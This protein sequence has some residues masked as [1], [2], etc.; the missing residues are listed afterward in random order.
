MICCCG[1]EVNGAFHRIG[2][3]HCLASS[4]ASSFHAHAAEHQH[5]D[6]HPQLRQP[7]AV[8][9]AKANHVCSSSAAITQAHSRALVMMKQMN[10]GHAACW[11]F[12]CIMECTSHCF[13]CATTV[14]LCKAGGTPLADTQ[15]RNAR[16][17]VISASGCCSTVTECHML[18]PCRVSGSVAAAGVNWQLSRRAVTGRLG[19]GRREGVR[20]HSPQRPS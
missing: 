12:L 5:L 4:C 10:T 18:C 14:R 8:P 17:R 6:N 19:G 20:Q 16:G 11:R 9:A 1:S 2:C 3:S 7:H 13:T 15:Q